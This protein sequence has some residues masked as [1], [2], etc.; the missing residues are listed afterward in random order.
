MLVTCIPINAHLYSLFEQGAV[1]SE[2]LIF[3][4]LSTYTHA[5]PLPLQLLQV[6]NTII[7]TYSL[8]MCSI[9]LYTITCKY[10]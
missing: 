2:C 8:K 7:C 5:K 3:S 4:S 6:I 1:Q 10:V 9:Y